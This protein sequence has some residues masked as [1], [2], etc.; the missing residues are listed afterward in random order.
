MSFWR[1]TYFFLKQC[2]IL[3]LAFNSNAYELGAS[4]AKLALLIKQ[5]NWNWVVA[6]SLS[7]GIALMK[8]YSS[9]SV[10]FQYKGNG[11]QCSYAARKYEMN[12]VTIE[13]HVLSTSQRMTA[14]KDWEFWHFGE[15]IFWGLQLQPCT[16]Q[17]PFITYFSYLFWQLNQ[18]RNHLD[19]VF[20]SLLQPI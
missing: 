12:Y 10:L 11:H 17:E 2:A 14:R 4:C 13:G 6:L 8:Y 9:V 19:G 5:P 7:T 18:R 1:K 15:V 3:V 16:N 20:I